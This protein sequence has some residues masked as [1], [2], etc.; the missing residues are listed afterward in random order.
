MS[1]TSNYLSNID[2]Q[3]PVA[4]RDNSTQG[5]RDNFRNIKLALDSADTDIESLKSSL[6]RGDNPVNEFYNNVIKEAVFQDCSVQVYDNTDTTQEGD[7]IVDYR[8][9]SYQKFNLGPNNH[10]ITITNW[11]STQ[12]TGISGFLTISFVAD[13][14]AD[15]FVTFPSSLGLGPGGPIYKV[16][17]TGESVFHAWNDGNSSNATYVKPQYTSVST[18]D[19]NANYVTGTHVVA[20]EDFVIGT[21][22]YKSGDN[23]QTVV[24]DGVSAGTV[25][26]I[27]NKITAI[28]TGTIFDD[29][30]ITTA[31][32]IPVDSTEGMLVG[33]K[34]NVENYTGSFTI[35]NI[36]YNSITVS[37]YFNEGP[38]FSATSLV[39]VV[40][41]VFDQDVVL[42]LRPDVITSTT[43]TL[44]DVRG[45]VSVSSSSLFV[46]FEDYSAGA[47]NWLE[48]RP[49]ENIMPIGSIIMWY[50]TSA[51]VPTGWQICDGTNSTPDLRNRFIIGADADNGSIPTSSVTG[52]ATST[53]GTKDAIVVTHDHTIT[54]PGHTHSG[55]TVYPYNGSG[56]QAE[57]NQDD[58]PPDDY[59][60]FN[61]ATGSSTTGITINST[62]TSGTN[63]NLPPYA[64]VFYIMKMSY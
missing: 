58:A 42:T 12:L 30:G 52:S 17:T 2:V 46:A 61:V 11:P 23:N 45:N 4:G 64:A 39:S 32:V 16:T 9:G 49:A 59:T 38:E 56:S 43:G 40:N 54:D 50:G 57:Q 27:P 53:G 51:S 62:G 37:P 29:I 6:I 31:T 47:T 26:L 5:F 33:A 19:V 7:I 63:Q 28:I 22:T 13:T 60:S 25:A 3:F 48:L 21:N 18:D 41:P 55:G 24:T 34:L 8:N 1:T 14:I 35:T 15:T 20:V 44:G 10:N 36:T